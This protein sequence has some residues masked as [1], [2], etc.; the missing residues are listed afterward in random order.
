MK[1][2]IFL[3]LIMLMQF[4]IS[5]AQITITRSDFGSI[6]DK[7]YY[8][9][10]TTVSSTVSPGT[11][12]AN[13][14]WNFKSVISPFYYDSAMFTDASSDPKAPTGTNLR[15]LEGIDTSYLVINPNYIRVL[16]PPPSPFQGVINIKVMQF[17]FTYLTQ[18][19][20]SSTLGV[21]G[22]PADFGQTFPGADSMLI[23][24]KLVAD[25]KCDG[26]GV[27][28]TPA[29][30]ISTLRFKNKTVP[31]LTVAVRLIATGTWQVVSSTTQAPSISY[32]WMANGAKD[33]IAEA[34]MD[35]LGT[36]IKKFKYRVNAL[37]N[38]AGIRSI[39][40][41]QGEFVIYPN[42]VNDVLNISFTPKLSPVIMQLLD[43]SGRIV[44][45]S[46][47]SNSQTSIDVSDLNNGIYF[48]SL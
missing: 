12:G 1:K 16:V 31:H 25:I 19:S 4:T 5:F 24:L 34:T 20:D 38:Y 26:W 44:K 15:I 14:N 21:K 39:S 11:A 23:V 43:I 45:Q 42:P 30:S 13:Q 33:M 2:S 47:L 6:G 8:A 35:S 36:S 32:S 41:A 37:P 3:I 40:N 7:V 9:L 17:P 27:I 18:F 22:T 29:D 46:N 10:D 48:I 28:V